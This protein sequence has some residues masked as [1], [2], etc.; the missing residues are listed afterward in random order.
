MADIRITKRFNAR[1]HGVINGKPFVFYL[2]EK[3][4]VPVYQN[5]IVTKDEEKVIKQTVLMG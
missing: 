1:I 5:R 4:V 3:R 2:K